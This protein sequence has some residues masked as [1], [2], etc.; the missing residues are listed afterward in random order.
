VHRQG[1]PRQTA[2]AQHAD[3]PDTIGFLKFN[4][5]PRELS[6]QFG[7]RPRPAGDDGRG[8]HPRSSTS[9][10]ILWAARRKRGSSTPAAG[11]NVATATSYAS[12]HASSRPSQVGVTSCTTSSGLAIAV[13]VIGWLTGFGHFCPKPLSDSALSGFPYF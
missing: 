6:P 4:R 2:R 8:E 13:M 1:E 10:S 7:R 9:A 12:H 5:P 11:H 3:R